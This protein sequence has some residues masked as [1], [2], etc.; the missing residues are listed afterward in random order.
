M[1]GVE[2]N[3]KKGLHPTDPPSRVPDRVAMA[4]TG[5]PGAEAS[6]TPQRQLPILMVDDDQVMCTIL[7]ALLKSCGQYEFVSTAAD[8][9]EALEA[10]E[11]RHDE[12]APPFALVFMDI[13]MPRMRGDDAIAELRSREA[14]GM[15]A[16]TQVVG[17][18]T[19][20]EGSM[21]V[22]ACVA[23]NEGWTRG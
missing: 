7:R 3:A 4:P 8:G 19:F 16:R 2:I 10:I 14:A 1:K 15:R 20:S 9:I 13:D 21:G 12:G 6:C 5:S 23:R 11:R 18:S 22:E 17:L